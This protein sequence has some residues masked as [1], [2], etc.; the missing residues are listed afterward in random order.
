MKRN[1]KVAA[2]YKRIVAPHAQ[3]LA[4]RH[5]Y[6]RDTAWTY[7]PEAVRSREL[8]TGVNTKLG[9]ASST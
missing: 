9:I 1:P 2:D 6:I 3:K 8:L 4:R 7:R 5:S